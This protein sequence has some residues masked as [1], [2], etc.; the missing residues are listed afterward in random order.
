MKQAPTARLG[1]GPSSVVLPQQPPAAGAT[2]L[3]FLSARF[4]HISRAEWTQRMVSG[5]VCDAEGDVLTHDAPY[6]AGARI[7]YFRSLP[8]ETPIHAQETVLYQDAHI[9]VAD[10]PHFLPVIPSGK[11]LHETLLVRLKHRLG[12]D[13]L[14]PVHRIDRDT[15]GLVLFSTDP[16]TR[17]AYHALFRERAVDKRYEAIAP[18]NPA[19]AWPITRRSRI[20]AAAHFM[21]QTEL[22]GEPNSWT[23]I[24]PLEVSG[25]WA[26]YALRPHTG[27]R[28]QLRVHM[29][30]LGLPIA[31]DGMYPV[32]TPEA[33]PDYARPLQLLA[34]S[35]AFTDPVSGQARHFESRHRLRPVSEFAGQTGSHHSP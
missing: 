22:D 24:A 5:S 8:G 3:D 23:E 4:A 12:L 13:D 9:L 29:A 6:R 21:Q 2:L 35:I 14:V 18:W 1:V 17:K 16:A 19:L 25:A 30:A 27:Q 15:A 26:R 34:R 33:A 10:K 31:G 7:H 11:Y 20:G 28:H 32:L